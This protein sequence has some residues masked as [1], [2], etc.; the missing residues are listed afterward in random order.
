MKRI[1]VY[2]TSS[3]LTFNFGITADAL[4]GGYLHPAEKSPPRAEIV[5]VPQPA[6]EAEATPTPE[7]EIVFGGGRLKLV[8]DEVHLSSD[9]LHYQI[10]VRYPQV[11][12]SADPHI[13]RLNQ[14]INELVTKEYEWPIYIVEE[15][16]HQALRMHPEVYNLVDIVYDVTS[17]TDSVLSIYFGE[18]SYGIGAAHGVQSSFVV[19]Y[20][21]AS[22]KE[23]KLSDLFKPG[24]KYLEFVSRYCK[25]EFKRQGHGESLFP[26][27]LV[28]VR[29][30]FESWNV[31]STGIRFN[32]DACTIF[33]C[34]GGQTE[35]EIPFSD[36]KP[37][38]SARAM[39]ILPTSSVVKVKA[40]H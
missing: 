6:L 39:S 36:L 3:L 37:I 29:R 17:A 2:V 32:F 15:E 28:P 18:Y 33:G 7:P 19:N 30:N 13:R 5:A 34:S 24:S 10:N 16:L 9:R 38:L 22:K 26:E 21:L 14:R 23:L 12:G 25:D 4:L 1:L 8:P 31:T 11:D 20:D 27:A 35:V 40:D